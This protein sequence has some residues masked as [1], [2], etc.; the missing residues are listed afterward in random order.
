MK[1]NSLCGAFSGA[2]PLPLQQIYIFE[3]WLNRRGRIDHE[4]AIGNLTAGKAV[5]TAAG[6]FLTGGARSWCE[7]WSQPCRPTRPLRAMPC[8][9][10]HGS[11]AASSLNQSKGRCIPRWK[12]PQSCCGT[13]EESLPGWSSLS[14][15]LGCGCRL[16]HPGQVSA[17][18]IRRSL[19]L[20]THPAVLTLWNAIEI[21]A[22]WCGR[23]RMEYI[24]KYNNHSQ[25]QVK[26]GSD[27]NESPN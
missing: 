12:S 22:Q 27:F 5:C 25:F 23:S 16:S 6:L 10:S 19:L 11:R 13:E 7:R 15:N 3:R 20:Y 1:V 18:S 8:R 14:A 21:K 2:L 24:W 9:H 4:H 17:W 26:Q